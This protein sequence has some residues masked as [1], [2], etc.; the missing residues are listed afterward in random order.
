MLSLTTLQEKVQFFNEEHWLPRK[1]SEHEELEEESE[2]KLL[3]VKRHAKSI[4]TMTQRA[5][6][7]TYVKYLLPFLDFEGDFKVQE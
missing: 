1:P 7:P 2:S 3:D 5:L 6:I 4:L